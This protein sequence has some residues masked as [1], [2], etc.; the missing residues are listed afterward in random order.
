VVATGWHD[1]LE[2]VKAK[3]TG[4]L[5]LPASRCAIRFTIIDRIAIGIITED[6][7]S[8]VGSPAGK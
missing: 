3:L 2:E 6:V 4:T 8:R 7:N 5:E 1:A